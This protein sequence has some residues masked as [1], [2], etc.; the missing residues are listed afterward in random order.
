MSK[1]TSAEIKHLFDSYPA[2]DQFYETSDGEVF[3]TESAATG[4]ADAQK[5]DDKSIEPITKDMVT[6]GKKPVTTAMGKQKTQNPAAAPAE[7]GAG[8]KKAASDGET[9]PNSEDTPEGAAE[10]AA[11]GEGQTDSE[12]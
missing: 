9:N 3:L 7:K 2:Q 4:Y 10:G 5:L 6:E 12:E 11:E 1:K 8:K